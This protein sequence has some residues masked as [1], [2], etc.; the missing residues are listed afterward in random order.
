[1]VVILGLYL[2]RPLGYSI[3]AL[4]A[5]IGDHI[6]KYFPKGFKGQPSYVGLATISMFYVPGR[7]CGHLADV[8]P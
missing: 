1:M 8:P 5:L 2:G 6:Y 4:M 7:L 3:F